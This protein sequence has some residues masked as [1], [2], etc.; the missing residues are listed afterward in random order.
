M[1]TSSARLAL[2]PELVGELL[3][4]AIILPMNQTQ[5]SEF[6]ELRRVSKTWQEVALSSPYLWS[7]LS[8]DVQDTFT[9]LSVRRW[10]D[11]AYDFPLTFHITDTRNHQ[12][13]LHAAASL[14]DLLNILYESR[15]WNSISLPSSRLYTS[16]EYERLLKR[17]KEAPSKPWTNVQRLDVMCSN[18]NFLST[19]PYEGES[20]WH[21]P[22]DICT[23]NLGHLQLEIHSTDVK[24]R[25]HHGLQRLSL[26]I[27]IA[28][29]VSIFNH[30]LGCLPELR[31]LEVRWDK[32]YWTTEPFPEV[33]HEKIEEISLHGQTALQFT[34]YLR[35]PNLKSLVLNCSIPGG[36]L[37]IQPILR[38]IARF[39]SVSGSSLRRLDIHQIQGGY[40]DSSVRKILWATPFPAL[41]HLSFSTEEFPIQL[42][43]AI[44]GRERGLTPDA[45]LL[46]SITRIDV[47]G[48]RPSFSME[49]LAVYFERRRQRLLDASELACRNENPCIHVV[50][51]CPAGLQIGESWRSTNHADAVAGLASMGVHFSVQYAS[52]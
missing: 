25:P 31:Q 46:P 50:L 5:R 15:N 43:H 7:G 20:M 2:P 24:L 21:L 39:L 10:L 14:N 30:I 36:E 28:K 9:P 33:V 12:S 13:P 18:H 47:Y 51:H 37:A 22:I 52:D 11:R 1:E 42:S 40:C 35:A 41:E 19:I 32:N 6:M 26:L 38:F 23:P 45:L 44:S 34:R 8:V 3:K 17:V 49:D 27:S 16:G 48:Q 4:W 29:M